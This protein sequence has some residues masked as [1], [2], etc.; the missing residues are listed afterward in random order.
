[1]FDKCILFVLFYNPDLSSKTLTLL[2]STAASSSA[3][4]TG[5]LSGLLGGQTTTAT[6]FTGGIRLQNEKNIM[7]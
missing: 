1:M 4:E 2:L 6:G 5:L 3:T 7:A